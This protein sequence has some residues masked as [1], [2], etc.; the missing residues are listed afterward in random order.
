[1]LA[2]YVFAA[3]CS[4]RVIPAYAR[5]FLDDVSTKAST[6]ESLLYKFSMTVT[7][8]QSTSIIMKRLVQLQEVNKETEECY[9]T[10]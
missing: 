5:V 1:M 8:W 6:I 4:D 7:F 10:A 9:S 3:S 2:S